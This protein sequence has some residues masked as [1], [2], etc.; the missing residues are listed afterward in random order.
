MK[1]IF[2]Y[3]VRRK[4]RSLVAV[5]FAPAVAAPVPVVV[6]KPL[7]AP[8]LADG[9]LPAPEPPPVTDAKPVPHDESY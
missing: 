6:T 8:V 1:P 4:R 5:D 7:A 3:Y 9:R 2:P